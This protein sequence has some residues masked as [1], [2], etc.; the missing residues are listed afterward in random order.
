MYKIL[1]ADDV[2]LTLATEKAYLEGRNLKVYTANS[3]SEAQEVAGVIQPD[4]IVLD[5]EMPEV[6]G[7]EA[8]RRLKANPRTS[9]IPVLILSIRDDEDLVATCERAG[10]SGFVRKADGREALLESVANMLGVPRRKRVRV[11]CTFTVGIV[12]GGRTYTGDVE[13]I[14]ASGM[15]LTAARGFSE[16]MALRIRFNLPRADNEIRLLGEVVRTEEIAE[17]RHGSGIQFL[18]MDPPSR[19][20]LSLYLENSL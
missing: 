3:G 15:F 13:N 9:H 4:L 18:E 16:G 17:D 8:C 5:Y 20:S 2:K 6:T 7:A 1:L 19:Q 11:P 14:S 10:A 12:E